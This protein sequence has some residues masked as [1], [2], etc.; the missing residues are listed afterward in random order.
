VP[1]TDWR[2]LGSPAVGSW[3]SVS[4]LLKAPLLLQCQSECR[5]WGERTFDEVLPKE[6]SFDKEIGQPT[7]NILSQSHSE[8][9]VAHSNFT[10]KIQTSC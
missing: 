7:C 5:G 3:V 10:C 6:Y 9:K 1:K 4:E 8:R 2:V